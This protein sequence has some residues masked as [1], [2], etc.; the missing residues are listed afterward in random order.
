[1]PTTSWAQI[2][3]EAM[4][5][6]DQRRGH[7]LAMAESAQMELAELREALKVRQTEL[8]KKLNITQVGVSRLERRPN[9]LL[10]S[11]SNYVEALGGELELRVIFPNRTIRLT[12]LLLAPNGKKKKPAERATASPEPTKSRRR[13]RPR[14]RPG[15]PVTRQNPR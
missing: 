5:K 8:A 15:R 2:K 1:M 11:I 13:A 3:D 14:P 6:R 9:V 12:H 10:R 7:E 4:S